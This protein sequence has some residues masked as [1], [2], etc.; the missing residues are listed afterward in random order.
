[1]KAARLAERRK[2]LEMTDLPETL[3]FSVITGF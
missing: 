1:V 2:P 3:G